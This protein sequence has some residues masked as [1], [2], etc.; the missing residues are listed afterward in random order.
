MKKIFILHLALVLNVL[1]SSESLVAAIEENAPSELKAFAE[2]DF[3]SIHTQSLKTHAVPV[4]ILI[5]SLILEGRAQ[6]WIAQDSLDYKEVFKRAGLYYPENVIFNSQ[7]YKWKSDILPAGLVQKEMDF[8]INANI[9]MANL[10]CMA[11]HSTRSYD[12]NGNRTQ[13]L[14]I[15]SPSDSFNPEI[16]VG[17]IYQ[18]MK[19]VNK[20]WKQS[21]NI[22]KRLFPETKI[23]ENFLLNTFIRSQ[24]NSYVKTHAA[25]DRGTPFHNGGPGLTNG[26]ASL[27]NVLKLDI[28]EGSASGYTSIP[29]LGDRGFRTSLL[30]DGV[31]SIAHKDESRTIKTAN[32]ETLKDAATIAALFTI[33][34]MGQT[35]KRSLKNVDTVV[36]ILVPILKSYKTP[37]YPWKINSERAIN[38]FKI[39]NTS[40]LQCHGEYQWNGGN[41]SQLISFPNKLIAQEDMNSDPER[42]KAISPSLV[43]NLEESVWNDL[44]KINQNQGYIAPILEGLW[45]TAPYMHN[46]SVPSLWHFLRPDM[47]PDA[48][49]VGNQAFDTIKI[50]S[51]GLKSLGSE[52]YD[53][54]VK[55]RSNNG[56]ERELENLSEDDKDDLLEYLK[57]L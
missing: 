10:S 26:V 1:L 19:K 34:T 16:Y 39:Y 27:K 50:G 30:A 29:S 4:K 23:K 17:T 22:V 6:K 40:C 45:A 57:T 28:N 15:G 2:S 13:N 31:Y 18:G 8:G 52:I 54:S 42:W 53:T 5:T 21:M 41:K 38:G 7:I 32:N 11:C 49:I 35:Q 14:L 33:P 47:R 12:Q 37:A 48:F 46:G 25:I 44:V 51:I 9:K 36:K 24:V 20:D 3:D 55:G 56:H 43:K